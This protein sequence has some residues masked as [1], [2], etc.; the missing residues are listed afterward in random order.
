MVKKMAKT[1][2]CVECKM[3]DQELDDIGYCADCNQRL[4]WQ[5]ETGRCG[6]C[7]MPVLLCVCDDDENWLL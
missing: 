1:G 6:W 5:K 7:K 3:K 4:N 2:T